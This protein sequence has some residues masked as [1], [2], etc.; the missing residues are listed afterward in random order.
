MKFSL[1]AALCLLV[2]PASVWAQEQTAHPLDKQLEVCVEKD[3]STA[4]MV[5]CIDVALKKWDQ[6]LNKNY[7]TL[8]GKLNPAG[9]QTLKTAQLDWIKYRDAEFKVLDT[10]YAT[11]QGTMYIPMHLDQKMQIVRHR[12]LALAGYLDLITEESDER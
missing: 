10:I 3:P 2:I 12:A 7:Q 6:Q 1:I 11:L 5:S 9:K 4:G 8:M